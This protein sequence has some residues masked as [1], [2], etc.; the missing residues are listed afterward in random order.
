MSLRLR[1][2]LAFLVG[3]MVAGGIVGAAALRLFQDYARAETTSELERQASGLAALYAE[4]VERE[5]GGEP[6]RFAPALLEQAADARI[7]Y[8]GVE[9]YPGSYTGLRRL[10]LDDAGLAE[11]PER[12]TLLRFSAPEGDGTRLIAAAAPIRLGGETFGALVVAKPNATLREQWLGLLARAAVAGLGGLLVTVVIYIYLSRRLTRPVLELA[13][14]VDRLERDPAHA[15]SPRGG[16][17]RDEIRLLEDRFRELSERLS[18]ARQAERSFL[19]SV[20]HELRTPLAAIRAHAQ[21]LVDGV[22]RRGAEREAS[23]ETI[24]GQAERLERLVGDL[25]DLAKLNAH[26]FR[27]VDE[28]VDLER[29]LGYV[30]DSFS[31]QA[32]ERECE[33]A[34]DTSERIV[35]RSDG[36]RLA[37]VIANLVANALA[38]TPRG[39]VVTL[40]LARRG[41]TAAITVRDT[42]PGVAEADREHIFEPLF[43]RARGGSGLGLAIARGLARALGGD[44][45]LVATPGDSER[46]KNSPRLND[47]HEEAVASSGHARARARGRVKADDAGPETAGESMSASRTEGACFQVTVPLRR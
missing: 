36:D 2:A 43:T 46:A 32:R 8:V 24:R 28:E 20:S 39:G 15:R 42:G 13:A 17:S 34:L 19:L 21:A 30:R 16:G 25:L 6:S 9:L 45:M 14:A 44:V 26:R 4:Q 35:A 31:E 38:W 27:L 5:I 40:A 10:E 12:L 33:L 47:G 23:L 11:L 22:F 29:L 37:Q 1:L 7:Y 41:E 3:I 18:E